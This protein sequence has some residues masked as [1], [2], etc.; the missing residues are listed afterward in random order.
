MSVMAPSGRRSASDWLDRV[1]INLNGCVHV[2]ILQFHWNA[3]PYDCA[4][5]HL[6]RNQLIKFGLV[7]S[8]LHFL[9]Y[10]RLLIACRDAGRLFCK[11]VQPLAR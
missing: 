9:L 3:W 8:R 11:R 10:K 6:P 7:I 5:G 4:F 1:C 2:L